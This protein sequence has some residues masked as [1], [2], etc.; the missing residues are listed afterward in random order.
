M[1]PASRYLDRTANPDTATNFTL[2]Y[3]PL[4]GQTVDANLRWSRNDIPV[5]RRIRHGADPV[6]HV[7]FD[8]LRSP[9]RMDAANTP[10]GYP[11]FQG[12]NV[13]NGRNGDWTV[14]NVQTPAGVSFTDAHD[15]VV[16][17][18]TF[19]HMANAALA[20]GKGT[21]DSTVINNSFSNISGN[22]IDVG[23]IMKSD[24]ADS[25]ATMVQGITVANNVIT[26]IGVEYHDNVGIF[27]GSPA[28]SW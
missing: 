11:D 7:Q 17:N 16:K 24:H 12:G 10:Q 14:T 21:K 5:A 1:R 19:T 9:R 6:H 26:K 3:K 2:H 25:A 20:F 27:L 23:G 18:S 13:F 15:I 8:G 4:A 28:T 22:G